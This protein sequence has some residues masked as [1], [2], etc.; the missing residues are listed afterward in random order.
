MPAPFDDN[1]RPHRPL[2]EGDRGADVEAL[3]RAI[4]LRLK[5]KK[6]LTRV[7][8]DGEIDADTKLAY[9]RAAY[10]IGLPHFKLTTQCQLIM[11]NP[12]RRTPQMLARARKNVKAWEA[13]KAG[14]GTNALRAA[15]RMVG[16]SERGANDA[17]WLRQMED[18]LPHNRLDWMIP[19]Q[20]YC[21]FGCIWS[22]WAGAKTLLPDGTVFTPNICPWGGKTL[23]KVKFVRVAPEQ[24]KP[25]ALVVINFG[26]GGA[27]HVALAR[28]PMRNGA[29]PTTE[30]N[31]SPTSAGSQANGDGVWKKTR[32]R[33]F[34]LCT[35][36]VEP[37]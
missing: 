29:I 25:G 16:K 17:P 23:G 18:D 21:G 33:G 8:V 22:W 13:R 24:A 10:L 20:P 32:P 1:A 34:V 11:R 12:A 37:V 30:F 35:L 3:Q 26:S 19:G 5:R 36:N 31:T 15:A 14:T 4:N 6:A 27:K 2:K 9:R 7:K 28:G